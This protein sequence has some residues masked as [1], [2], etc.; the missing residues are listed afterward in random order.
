[1]KIVTQAMDVEAMRVCGTVN[2]QDLNAQ[3]PTIQIQ[4]LRDIPSLEA[5]GNETSSDV[6]EVDAESAINFEGLY[7]ERVSWVDND[8]FVHFSCPT[9]IA[10]LA[11]EITDD[12]SDPIETPLRCITVTDLSNVQ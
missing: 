10:I 11:E 12:P 5:E 6:C 1:M 8:M 4:A 2:Y 3:D 7:I 9:D